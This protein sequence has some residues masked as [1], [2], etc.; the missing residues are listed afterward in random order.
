VPELRSSSR[1]ASPES[2]HADSGRATILKTLAFESILGDHDVGAATRNE[3]RGDLVP[4]DA[5]E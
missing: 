5:D 1:S 2:A 4:L 3:G